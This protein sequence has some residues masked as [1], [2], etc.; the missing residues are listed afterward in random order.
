MLLNVQIHTKLT[1]LL[2]SNC[3]F[4]N[5]LKDT[6]TGKWSVKYLAEVSEE[7]R[8][9]PLPIKGE[10]S[11][12]FSPIV[13]WPCL[14]WYRYETKS[15][16]ILQ[17]NCVVFSTWLLRHVIVQWRDC[18]WSFESWNFAQNQQVLSRGAF[19]GSCTP[20]V[21]LQRTNWAA[22]NHNES[23]A[24][25][26]ESMGVRHLYFKWCLFNVAVPH[27]DWATVI[28]FLE[29]ALSLIF[30]CDAFDCFHYFRSATLWFSEALEGEI[31]WWFLS[32]PFCTMWE[33]LLSPPHRTICHLHR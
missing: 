19:Q 15:H 2:C 25:P 3:K 5:I 20:L 26:R 14:T 4:W 29:S 18:Y 17:I 21:S 1:A 7:G 23:E 13:A 30:S 12:S 27:F 22:G 10:V 28:I 8:K 11:K 16:S 31:Q 9:N 24:L 33:K 32:P 6:C